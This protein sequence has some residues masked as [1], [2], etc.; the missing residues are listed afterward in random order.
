M[1]IV[2]ETI[3]VFLINPKSSL[4]I[5]FMLNIMSYSL[6]ETTF[7]RVDIFPSSCIK[8][9][10]SSLVNSAS[11]DSKEATYFF[12]AQLNRIIGPFVPDDGEI[13]TFRK[14]MY[15]RYMCLR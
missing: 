13:S 9:T 15:I 1:Y 2:K 6:P 10:G 8:A 7:R 5:V 11:L 4:E 3:T 12:K 14:M